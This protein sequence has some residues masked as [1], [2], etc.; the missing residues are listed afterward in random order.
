MV[1]P[2]PDLP[3]M[4]GKIGEESLKLEQNC[5]IQLISPIRTQESF[6][7]YRVGVKMIWTVGL[8]DGNRKNRSKLRSLTCDFECLRGRERSR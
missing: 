8:C 3:T 7:I 1:N 5:L 2:D 4:V 6:L